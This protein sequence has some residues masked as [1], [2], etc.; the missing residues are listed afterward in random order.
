VSARPKTEAS[1]QDSSDYYSYDNYYN[2]EAQENGQSNDVVVEPSFIETF[3]CDDQGEWLSTNLDL[4]AEIGT[5]ER[6]YACC[7]NFAY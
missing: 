1:V 4:H 5:C 3:V 2:N 6:K 7:F